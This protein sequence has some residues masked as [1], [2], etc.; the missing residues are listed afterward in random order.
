MKP[1]QRSFYARDTLEVTRDLLGALL[2][3]DLPEGRTSGR[4]VEVEAYVGEEDAACHAAAGLTLRTDPLYGPPGHAYIYFI[5][6]VHW[7]FNAVT[8]PKGLPSAVLVR[9][10]EPVEGVELMRERRQGRV[11]R[12]LTNG[13][14]KLARAMGIG[15]EQNRAD[16]TRGRLTIRDGH[17]V[18]DTRVAWGPR[19]GIRVAA[20]LRYRAWLRGNPHVSRS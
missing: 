9:A 19:V 3:H 1:L 5:Y 12:E 13:P 17:R 7:C 8:R 11:D 2:V 16:L 20:D 4:I 10:L 15:P 6:G 18:P 14:G